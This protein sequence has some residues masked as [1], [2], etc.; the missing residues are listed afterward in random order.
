MVYHQINYIHSFSQWGQPV[1]LKASQSILVEREIKKTPYRDLMNAYPLFVCFNPSGLVEDF[2]ALKQ[3]SQRVAVLVISDPYIE[4][5]KALKPAFPHVFKP[6]K[7]HHYI[8]F[9]RPL[10]ISKHHKYYANRALKQVD[11]ELLSKPQDYL[12]EWCHI[13]KFLVKK[14]QFFGIKAFSKDAFQWQF[15]TPGLIVFVARYQSQIVSMHLWYK[16]PD[17]RIIYSHLAAS[18]ALGYE[19]MASYAI[20]HQAIHYF[21]A[22][23]YQYIHLGSGAGLINQNEDGLSYFKRGWSNQKNET[24]LCGRILQPE[25]YE[26]LAQGYNKHTYFPA[27]R[28]GDF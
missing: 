27:Y 22:L 18:N 10:N 21:S 17:R 2:E 9:E 14:H 3:D 23:D 4:D 6:F 16:D 19:L 28:V 8:D 13:Y 7:Q 12:D 5:I 11:V 24:Y 25:I 20:Y 26:K 1:H 15:K